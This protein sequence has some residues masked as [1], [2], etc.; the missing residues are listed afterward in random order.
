MME[1]E[2]L[3]N[4]RRQT[5][6]QIKNQVSLKFYYSVEEKIKREEEQIKT[7]LRL[8]E[9]KQKV[10]SAY[11]FVLDPRYFEQKFLTNQY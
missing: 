10:L 11:S 8:E 1:V 6:R 3:F 7:L 9:H 5:L 2:S 4:Q